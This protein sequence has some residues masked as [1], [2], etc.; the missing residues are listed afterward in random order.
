MT[1]SVDQET[2]CGRF[3]A[4]FLACT[5]EAKVGIALA[6]LKLTPLNVSFAEA[7]TALADDLSVTGRDPEHSVGQSRFITFGV[8]SAGRLLVVSHKERGDVLRIISARLATK[9]E[10]R[11]YEEG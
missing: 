2:V 8:S 10:R 1:G 11:I 4:A 3:G 7:A 5:A 9:Q 6:T